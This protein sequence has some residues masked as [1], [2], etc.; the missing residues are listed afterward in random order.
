MEVASRDI[1]YLL[2]RKALAELTFAE[3]QQLK[4]VPGAVKAICSTL[5]KTWD[6]DLDL[7]ALAAH[8]RRLSD[9]ARIETYV[10]GHLPCRT[11][12][13]RDLVSAAIANLKNAVRTLGPV[14][15]RGMLF[16]APCW[17]RL[18]L[19]LTQRTSVEWHSFERMKK[20]LSWMQGSAISTVFSPDKS[21]RQSSVVCATP[22]H[23][24]MEAL[25]WA[26]EL[27]VA[28]RARPHE[29]A[30]VAAATQDW[31]EKFRVLLV[32]SQLPVHLA[33]GRSAASTYPG[34]QAASLATVLVQG[35]SHDR[36]VQAL[37]LLHNTPKLRS[38]L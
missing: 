19:A 16:V 20:H 26:R 13:P 8:N 32:D 10:R 23:E 2:V 15:V 21:P 24:V 18:F 7:Q 33:Q 3:L 29:I 27:I 14:V 28:G 6:A 1:C 11:M 17:R 5:A 31:D 12:L 36:V 4:E 30:I 35:L 37:R 22:K 38:P 34:Q 25:R 9:L